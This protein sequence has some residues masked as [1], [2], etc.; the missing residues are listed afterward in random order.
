MPQLVCCFSIYD[1]T[2]FSLLSTFLFSGITSTDN[3]S[4]DSDNLNVSAAVLSV[5]PILVVADHSYKSEI[6]NTSDLVGKLGTM[7]PSG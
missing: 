7:A 6:A 4:S 3:V 5:E 1:W 2:N